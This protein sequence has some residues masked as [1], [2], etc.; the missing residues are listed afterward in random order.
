[1]RPPVPTPVLGGGPWGDRRLETSPLTGVVR[2]LP[3]VTGWT[4]VEDDRRGRE[5][6]V[7]EKETLTLLYT[8]PSPSREGGP[9]LHPKSGKWKDSSPSVSGVL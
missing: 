9:S 3:V 6:P 4:P 2:R 7:R 5:S 8:H 1:M